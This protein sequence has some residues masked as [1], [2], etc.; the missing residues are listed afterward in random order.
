ML[1]HTSIS[2]Y[3]GCFGNPLCIRK[4]YTWHVACKC[5]SP[6]PDKDSHYFETKV[7]FESP[8]KPD[9]L[10]KNTDTPSVSDP[11]NACPVH[12]GFFPNRGSC[13]CKLHATC[14]SCGHRTCCWNSPTQH[15]YPHLLWP[16]TR[17]A[18]LYKYELTQNVIFATHLFVTNSS[19]WWHEPLAGWFVTLKHLTYIE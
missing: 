7:R 9:N 11:R 6:I 14:R 8:L 4:I 10:N 1:L 5:N 19:S 18:C 15:S 3:K 17:A 12:Y 16:T 2:P 13:I